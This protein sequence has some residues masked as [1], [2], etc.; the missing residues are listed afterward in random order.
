M[1][2]VPKNRKD[3][4]D[5]LLH[6]ELQQFF[7]IT[8]SNGGVFGKLKDFLITQKNSTKYFAATKFHLYHKTKIIQT[9]EESPNLQDIHH[10]VRKNVRSNCISG[11]I[12][13]FS[14]LKIAIPPKKGERSVKES[15]FNCLE[16]IF[17]D[18]ATEM[19]YW[20]VGGDWYQVSSRYTFEVYAEYIRVL[21]ASLIDRD[22]SPL[23][24]K[25]PL[26]SELDFPDKKSM[27]P[28]LYRIELKKYRET[29]FVTEGIYNKLYKDQ[30]SFIV[31]DSDVAPY[32]VEICDLFQCVPNPEGK[33]TIYL[34]HVKKAFN[35]DGYRV[36]ICQILCSA[37]FLHDSFKRDET[38]RDSAAFKL[39]Q[40][41]QKNRDKSLGIY[42]F[43]D[44]KEF[45][46]HLRNAT[47]VFSP[48]FDTGERELDKD[49]MALIKY[50]FSDFEDEIEPQ[51]RAGLE[52]AL[53]SFL[54]KEEYILPGGE[55]TAKWFET[56]SVGNDAGFYVC[57]ETGS[58]I[59][60]FPSREISNMD[61]KQLRRILKGKYY[62]I[63]DGLSIKQLIVHMSEVLHSMGF[64]LKICQIEGVVDD[65]LV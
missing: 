47:F 11:L 39:F 53:Y 65:R 23:K 3:E 57:N 44:Y 2:K 15:L 42:E 43:N 4:L 41:I 25:W 7:G 37:Y 56:C 18:D 14:E 61:P 54:L 8:N 38:S 26:K 19:S 21:K 45:M 29:R 27:N 28:K 52:I 30:P 48:L 6:N 64:K 32:G 22:A 40:Y 55:F 13:K 9:F 62:K 58:F 63:V 49:F 31:T 59:D 46:E 36:A 51:F 60:P 5:R 33:P 10:I 12:Q 50:D 1:S 35:A 34:Y 17:Y 20:R 24:L 16:G